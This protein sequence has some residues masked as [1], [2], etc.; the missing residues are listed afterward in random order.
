MKNMRNLHT[1]TRFTDVNKVC[2]MIYVSLSLRETLC[3]YKATFMAKNTITFNII[4]VSMLRFICFPLF[5]IL[6]I[7]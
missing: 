6:L 3:V 1:P 4:I 2:I 7:P 5:Y